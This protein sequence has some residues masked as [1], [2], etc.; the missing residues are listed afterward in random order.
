VVYRNA[1]LIL[2]SVALAMSSHA[3]AANSA[4]DASGQ[5]LDKAARIL[6]HLRRTRS[7]Q[8][9]LAESL[10]VECAVLRYRDHPKDALAAAR[11]IK[12][13]FYT[14]LALGGIAAQQLE[15]DPAQAKELFLE[16]QE[17]AIEIDHWTGS[18]ATSLGYLFDL[19]P[20]F[21]PAQTKALL[22]ISRKNLQRWNASA[23]QKSHP[24]AALSRA[25]ISVN[26]SGVDELL[27]EVSNS[28][29]SNHYH[30][31]IELLG[32]FVAQTRRKWAAKEAKQFYES[33]DDWP[34]AF[35]PLSAV[36]LEDALLDL[37][38]ARK[39]I[40]MLPDGPQDKAWVA[41]AQ[42]LEK[43]GRMEEALDLLDE[44]DARSK[45]NVRQARWIRDAVRKFRTLW[46]TE[47][48]G[49]VSAKE[50]D[51]LMEMPD[52]STLNAMVYQKRP[53][54]FRNEEQAA[55]FVAAALP[56]VRKMKELGYPHHGSPR[57]V[58]LGALA[59]IMAMQ[60]DLEQAENIAR[61]IAIPEL[62]AFYLMEAYVA[63]RPLPELLRGWPIYYYIRA[64]IRIGS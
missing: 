4:D 42:A 6:E 27:Q 39:R 16:A 59:R 30:E 40:R 47:K 25:M 11:A 56:P 23:G 1:F 7:F 43:V 60:K 20:L 2:L 48:L 41:V 9:Y 58:L 14:S 24:M 10:M 46:T 3:F 13:P 52:S 31:S 17:R 54:V 61:E 51:Q 57:S 64:E 5:I 18:D 34:F 55:A 29:Q 15:S 21:E 53:I 49:P 36:L 33:G 32:R 37:P 19:I 28:E 63:I 8:H 35:C 50:I 62:R 44:V 45:A 22:A 12:E 26:P 38:R